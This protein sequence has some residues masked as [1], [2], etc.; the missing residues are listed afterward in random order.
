MPK[1]KVSAKYIIKQSLK[2]FR[3][4]GYYATSMKDI[5]DAC[6]LQKGSLYY[7]FA[8]KEELMKAVIGHLHEYYKREVFA[9]AY[10][11]RLGGRQNCV[12]WR[13]LAK[14]NSLAPKAAA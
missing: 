8:S 6:D 7:H 13:T 12:S 9:H 14:N 11:E 1:Q 10:D 2:V 4:K 5:A 3:T